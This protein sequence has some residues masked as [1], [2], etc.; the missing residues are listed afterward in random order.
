M[1]VKLVGIETIDY[2]STKKGQQVRG[3]NLHCVLADSNDSVYGSAVKA[4]YVSDRHSLYNKKLPLDTFYNLYF[5]QFGG[6]DELV[7]IKK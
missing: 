3:I 5:N 2:Y 7:E 6:V 4:F 1:V